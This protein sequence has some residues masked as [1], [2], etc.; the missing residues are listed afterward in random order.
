MSRISW[1]MCDIF[2]VSDCICDTFINNG[3]LSG[4]TPPPPPPYTQGLHT[5]FILSI[6]PHPDNN[7]PVW[8]IPGAI[9]QLPANPVPIY[10]VHQNNMRSAG[11]NENP[12]PHEFYYSNL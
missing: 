4:M 2:E 10:D 6:W 8:N 1:Q 11:A 5:P 9:I 3:Q 7:L 12:L